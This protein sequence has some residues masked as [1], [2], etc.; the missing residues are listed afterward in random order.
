MFNRFVINSYHHF[1]PLHVS[2]LPFY[3]EGEFF[4]FA[5]LGNYPTI[6]KAKFSVG[7]FFSCEVHMGCDVSDCTQAETSFGSAQIWYLF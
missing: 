7:W 1:F 4:V 3:F 6:P 2:I 5:R